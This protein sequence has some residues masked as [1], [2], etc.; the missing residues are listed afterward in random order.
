M[1]IWTPD[2]TEF[3]GPR[4]KRIATAIGDAVH[5]GT[6]AAG[7]R[8]PT[9]RDLAYNLNVTVGTVTRA[10]K[11]AERRGLLDGEVGRGTFI[12]QLETPESKFVITETDKPGIIDLGL[13]FPP[14][15][16]RGE[17]FRSTLE[18]LAIEPN[19][20]TLLDYHAAAG[21]DRHRAAGAKLMGSLGYS[22]N[23]EEILVTNGAQHG[24]AVA[25]MSLC[26]AGDTVLTEAL[27]YPVTKI[28]ASQLSL[29]LHG[30]AMDKDGMIPESLEA[31][32]QS[33]GARVLYFMPSYHNPTGA[34]MPEER[35]RQ[36]AEIGVRYGL[37]II[38]DDVFGHMSDTPAPPMSAIAPDIC[39]HLISTKTLA[40]GLRIGFLR[41]PRK[42]I[43]LFETSIRTT[44]WMGSP[45]LGEIATR[46]INDGTAAKIYQWHRK[47]TKK[48]RQIAND[49]LGPHGL[50]ASEKGA[51]HVWFPL[52]DP[53]HQEEFI[54]E[55][56]RRGVGLIGGD[57]FAVG[58]NRA[59]H[60]I[61][62]CLGC[63]HDRDDVEEGLTILADILTAS[64]SANL[65]VV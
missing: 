64:P 7:D 12:K 49:I 11:E 42:L 46:W 34:Y 18:Q 30:I 51:Y 23:P 17:A 36:I 1:T 59:P 60:A 14:P 38:D 9:H 53:W 62:I 10:Y 16:N 19:L 25:L 3:S 15:G 52:P 44:G 29:K 32:C 8:L 41:V 31:A 28:L 22:P 63:T 56:R 24:M 26:K 48:R 50:K 37:T 6:L 40:P 2:L 33:T 21:I 55:A 57:T 35:R 39:C 4:Y 45:I 54:A 27:T 47:E 20:A 43:P 5:K 61:R 65:A 13:N 58:R